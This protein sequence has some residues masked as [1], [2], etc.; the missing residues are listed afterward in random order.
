MRRLICM[1]ILRSV[2]RVAVQS[3]NNIVMTAFIVLMMSWLF[4]C[5][6]YVLCRRTW[7]SWLTSPSIG[8][9]NLNGCVTASAR[10]SRNCMSV[11]SRRTSLSSRLLTTQLFTST[12][13]S[14]SRHHPCRTQSDKYKKKTGAQPQIGSVS[15]SIYSAARQ[16]GT[17][18]Q[19]NLKIL[20]ASIVLNGFRR[21]SSLAATSVTSALE[22]IL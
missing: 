14:I 22:V 9:V 3:V 5:Q 2:I 20:T 8:L 16:S 11:K 18:C 7:W 19:M 4:L 10:W 1:P 6:N 13:S 21:Q 12:F 15:T 17:R